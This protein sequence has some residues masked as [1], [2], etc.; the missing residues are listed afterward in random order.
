MKKA[1]Y[2]Y[3]D[4]DVTELTI[5]EL[6]EVEA[7]TIRARIEHYQE[8]WE[9]YLW[10]QDISLERLKPIGMTYEEI[11]ASLDLIDRDGQEAMESQKRWEKRYV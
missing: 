8:K 7:A 3:H 5:L 10:L 11:I 6:T 9:D 1:W 2:T 4:E